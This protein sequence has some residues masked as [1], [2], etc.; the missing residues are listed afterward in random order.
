V[1]L[2]YTVRAASHVDALVTYYLCEKDRP[3]AVR[4]L[5]RTL[6][7]ASEAIL[8]QTATLYDAPRPYPAVCEHGTY[9]VYFSPYWI[10]FRRPNNPVISAVFYAAA[11]IP[12]RIE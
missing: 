12:S 2:P 3:E 5:Y 4:S 6:E 8:A 9:W 1:I 10:A 11:D 7:A